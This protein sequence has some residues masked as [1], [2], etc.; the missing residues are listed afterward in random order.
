MT[1]PTDEEPMPP[2]AR[3]ANVTAA[4]VV[5]AL[6][7][8]GALAA[9]K[10]APKAAPAAAEVNPHHATAVE[11]LARLAEE[12]PTAAASMQTIAGRLEYEAAHR[13][14]QAI[15]A[16]AVFAAL[17]RAG[18]PIVDGPRQYVGVVAAADYCAGGRTA[19][20]LAVVV[21]EYPTADRAAAGKAAVEQRFAAL[22]PMRDIVVR[23]ATTLTLTAGPDAALADSKRRATEAFTT[24]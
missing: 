21:C 11:Q 5:T 2:T 14:A 13:P 24:L 19:D 1:A 20:G 16:E 23:G 8:T 10:R 18:V 15:A 4:A 7:A 12:D 17:D 22:A 6:A 3:A 9:C